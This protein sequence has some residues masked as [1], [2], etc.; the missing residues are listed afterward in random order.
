VSEPP[1]RSREK[2]VTGETDGGIVEP[3]A[4]AMAVVEKYAQK[5]T[6]WDGP[7]T[8]PKAQPG[9]TIVVL[10]G[11]LKNGGILGVTT[12]VEE[13]AKAIGWEVK[14]IDGAGSI[15][16]RTAAFGQ[17]MALK[18]NGIVINGFDAVEQAPA[19]EQAKA[20]GI[21]LVSWHAG[22]V[23][24]PDEKSG[25]F[26]NVSTDA[27]QVSTADELVASLHRAYAEP[28]PHLIEAAIPA[29]L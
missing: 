11:D 26:A 28:G 4:D 21:P 7:T 1:H 29:L 20:A 2:A 8:G 25:V 9:K 13:A 3:L 18:P 19:L 16:G 27:M 14:V 6:A 15:G 23:I 10:A 22:P 12:G 17:A 24:G 5:V